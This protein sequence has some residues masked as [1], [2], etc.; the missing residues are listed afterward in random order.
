MKPLTATLVCI[1]VAL[2]AALAFVIGRQSAQISVSNPLPPRVVPATVKL[3]DQ[4]ISPQ[5]SPEPTS[6]KI[7][8]YKVANAGDIKPTPGAKPFK[9]TFDD[10]TLTFLPTKEF[11]KLVEYRI[12]SETDS[13]CT[14]PYSAIERVT[15][16]KY[17]YGFVIERFNTWNVAEGQQEYIAD[18]GMLP[19]AWKGALHD[20][21]REGRAVRITKQRCGMGQVAGLVSVRAS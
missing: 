5:P 18:E 20:I 3:A 12:D 2:A 15:K 1:I 7:S 10:I 21:V 6:E 9:E 11:R 13:T 14:K 8:P 4:A 16:V 17:V 19:N